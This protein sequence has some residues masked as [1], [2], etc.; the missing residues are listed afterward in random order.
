MAQ[1][2]LKLVEKLKIHIGKSSVWYVILPYLDERKIVSM[3]AISKYFYNS[4]IPNVTSNVNSIGK[5]SLKRNTVRRSMI[6]PG[7]AELHVLEDNQWK[8]VTVKKNLISKTKG[9]FE[10]PY[11]LD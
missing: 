3:Q 2:S 5:V 4:V 6:L 11:S 9:R 8:A 7:K 1:I 10:A